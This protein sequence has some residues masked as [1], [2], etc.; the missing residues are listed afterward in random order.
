MWIALCEQA[1]IKHFG[2]VIDGVLYRRF[3][4]ERLSSDEDDW[5]VIKGP[6]DKST[7]EG[8]KKA[9]EKNYKIMNNE[10]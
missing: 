9:A 7:A 3:E 8:I 2:V 1:K 10:E 5:G 4:P 6:F